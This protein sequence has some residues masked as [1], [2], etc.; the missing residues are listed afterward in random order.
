MLPP[1]Y[2]ICHH[3][4][5]NSRGGGV[6]I[7]FDE[8]L[9]IT[10]LES[11]DS[12]EYIS[13]KTTIN[14]QQFILCCV[15]RPPSS[16]NQVFLDEWNN[17]LS[18][19]TVSP[20]ELL[21]C[22]DINLHLDNLSNTYSGLFQQSLDAC[23]MVQHVNEPTHHQCHTLDILVTRKV[24]SL[25]GNISVMDPMLCNEDNVVIKDHYA[26]LATL[27]V[28]KPMSESKVIIHYTVRNLN[29]NELQ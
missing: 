19:L 7:V 21:I 1:N 17:L 27:N 25:I 4:R 6:A 11:S 29:N 15:Y 18:N 24:N 23:G 14:K 9:Y 16:S 13:C 5:A 28:D 3:D 8:T 20:Y 12:L 2:K 26:I 10:T 22:G